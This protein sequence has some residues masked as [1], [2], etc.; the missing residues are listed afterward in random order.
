MN[1]N[2]ITKEVLIEAVDVAR[3][4]GFGGQEDGD[5]P[6]AGMHTLFKTSRSDREGPSLYCSPIDGWCWGPLQN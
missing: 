1:L 4:L 6:E 3:Q 5:C 2:E